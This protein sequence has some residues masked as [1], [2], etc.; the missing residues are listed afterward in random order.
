[1]GRTPD[2]IEVRLMADL[3]KYLKAIS[4]DVVEQFGIKGVVDPRPVPHITLFGPTGRQ[5]E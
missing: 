1:M 3:Q 5:S 2:L 4:Y